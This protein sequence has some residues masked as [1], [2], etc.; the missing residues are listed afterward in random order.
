MRTERP[1]HKVTGQK[2]MGTSAISESDG[3]QNPQANP[4]DLSLHRHKE[5]HTSRF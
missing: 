3:A 1:W 2:R 4:N 5:K